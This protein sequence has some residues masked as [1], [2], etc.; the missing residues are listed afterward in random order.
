MVSAKKTLHLNSSL[1]HYIDMIRI[2]LSYDT[3]SWGW[4]GGL[5]GG[6]GRRG[7]R[8]VGKEA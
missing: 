3:P 6:V 2:R 7:G 8:G 4:G 5:G 1:L